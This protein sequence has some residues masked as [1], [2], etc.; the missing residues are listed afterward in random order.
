MKTAVALHHMSTN[1]QKSSGDSGRALHDQQ[2]GSQ[3]QPDNA[4][5]TSSYDS[6]IPYYEGYSCFPYLQTTTVPGQHWSEWASTDI[7]PQ[8]IMLGG[9]TPGTSIQQNRNQIAAGEGSK[10]RFA[11]ELCPK[12]YTRRHDLKR[13]VSNSHSEERPYSC[14]QCDKSFSRPDQLK[15]SYSF[16]S[17]F[18]LN[19]AVSFPVGALQKELA[20]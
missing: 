17:P 18:S 10:H 8:G 20:P 4:A 6:W 15:V 12:S 16:P 13:H 14:E 9:E 1:A 5:S 2:L 19:C 3:A 7:Q 11:C